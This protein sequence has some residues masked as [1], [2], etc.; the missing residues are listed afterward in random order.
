MLFD[1]KLRRQVRQTN[2]NKINKCLFRGDQ[3]KEQHLGLF[4]TWHNTPVKWLEIKTIITW[5]I[6]KGES[7]ILE[8]GCARGKKSKKGL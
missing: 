7:H 2:T 4:I 5:K 6:P 8:V 1:K 3:T